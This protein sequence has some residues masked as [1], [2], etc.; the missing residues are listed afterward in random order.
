MRRQTAFLVVLCLVVIP[1]TLAN[2]PPKQAAQQARGEAPPA[3]PVDG[4]L[5]DPM[6]MDALNR[7]KTIYTVE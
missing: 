3:E 2:G 6:M 5:A 7:L 1:V 4:L